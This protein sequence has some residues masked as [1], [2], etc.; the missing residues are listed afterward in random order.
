MHCYVAEHN[1][2]MTVV[3]QSAE[4]FFLFVCQYKKKQYG[5]NFKPEIEKLHLILRIYNLYDH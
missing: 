4:N 1:N 5:E 2:K 3:R